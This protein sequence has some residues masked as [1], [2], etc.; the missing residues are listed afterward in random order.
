MSCLL[1]LFASGSASALEPIDT[2]GPDFV[3]SS[4]VMPRGRFQ[5]E[6][7]AS[8]ARRRDST[9]A[10]TTPILLKQ[11]AAKDLELRITVSPYE[12]A[13]ASSG[14]GDA[15]FG[16]KWHTQDRDAPSGRPAVAWIAD[17]AAPTGS[18]GFR[19]SGIRPGLR[20]V[21][22]WDL[23]HELS[24]GLMPGV[25]YNSGDDGHRYT[26]AIAGAVLNERL[27]DSLRVF[28]E[29]SAEQIAHRRDGGVIASWDVG[30][31][32]LLGRDAQLG[33]RAGIA[34]TRDAPSGY[35]LLELAQRF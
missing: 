30:A 6:I 10:L 26:S 3:E 7:D 25:K 27:S 33:V 24:L 2:D 14:Y 16:F 22:T 13:G 23:P 35:L 34:A 32:R 21:I 11:G 19:S 12:R 29:A 17:F 28:V 9:S 8:R 4:E 18:S 15:V 20:S 5:Y 1:L 31:A